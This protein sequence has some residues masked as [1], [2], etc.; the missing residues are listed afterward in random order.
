MEEAQVTW[1][2]R[3]CVDG[4]DWEMDKGVERG[5]KEEKQE[6]FYYAP[7]KSVQVPSQGYF[8]G[9]RVFVDFCRSL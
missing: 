7:H 4:K 8:T 6:T 9:I 5:W 2:A 3:F 1:K